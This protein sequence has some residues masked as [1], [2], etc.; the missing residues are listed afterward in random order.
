MIDKMI[1]YADAALAEAF[2]RRARPARHGSIADVNEAADAQIA[3][4]S[5]G[6]E[7]YR[8]ALP[9]VPASEQPAAGMAKI[10]KRAVLIRRG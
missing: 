9:D 2:K 8:R 6:A 5:Q 10:A 1:A 3:L 7:F 4:L